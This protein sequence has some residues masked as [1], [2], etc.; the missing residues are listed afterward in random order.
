MEYNG[1]VSDRCRIIRQS[2]IR[3]KNRKMTHQFTPVV[4]GPE[5]QRN[6]IANANW[7]RRNR[8][9]LLWQRSQ[10]SWLPVAYGSRRSALQQ[11]KSSLAIH[12]GDERLSFACR[13]WWC[14]SRM[15]KRYHRWN[16][17]SFGHKLRVHGWFNR[18][19]GSKLRG[20][21]NHWIKWCVPENQCLQS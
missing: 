1:E 10:N 9:R 7:R 6:Y 17:E 2:E 19:D 3:R 13:K 18:S 4:H 11:T 15:R 21:Q 16:V 12:I 14:E 20:M 8:R 5:H